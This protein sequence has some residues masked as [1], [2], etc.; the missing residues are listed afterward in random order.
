MQSLV[1]GSEKG[2]EREITLWALVYL[3]FFFCWRFCGESFGGDE[4]TARQASEKLKIIA[5]A[6]HFN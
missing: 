5:R 4:Q 2:R 6:H 3:G 1:A